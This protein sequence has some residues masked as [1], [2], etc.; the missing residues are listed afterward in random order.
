M[1]RLRTSLTALALGTVTV[2]GAVVGTASN[3]AAAPVEAV[4]A[5]ADGSLGSP[6]HGPAV[7]QWWRG[8]DG[9]QRQC[10]NDAGLSRPVG[11]L[12]DSERATVREQVQ[13]A[14]D[15]CGV[16]LPFAKARAFWNTLSDSQQQCLQ[17]A[18][19]TRPLGRLS[20][21]ERASVRAE[22]AAAAQA[23]GVTL[24]TRPD[25]ADTVIP[26]S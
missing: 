20:D 16:T 12:S 5:F 23:C 11:P 8:L 2:T 22:M 26:G 15:T 10:L 17:D 4:T 18:D 25:A 7:R 24:P 13:A 19:V 21:D 3:A 6:G 14:A 9:T 1:N